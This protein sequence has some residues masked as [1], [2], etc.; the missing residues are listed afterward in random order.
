[1]SFKI[2]GSNPDNLSNKVL[3]ERETRKRM[4]KHARDI[5]CE[6]DMVLLMD[7][8][9]R[10]LRN[11]TNKKERDD[12]AQVAIFAIYN[13]LGRGGELYVDGKL[14]YKEK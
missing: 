4:L 13:L 5:G 12:I 7:K 9:D 10:L 3:S 8:Y 6:S 2:D 14:V 1:M 11:C